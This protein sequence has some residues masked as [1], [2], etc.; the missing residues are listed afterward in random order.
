MGAQ[1]VDADAYRQFMSSFPT[2]VVVVTTVGPD[3]APCGLT[4]SSMTSVSL[5]PPVLSICLGAWSGTLAALRAHGWFAVNLLDADGRSTAEQFAK[6]GVDHF[7]Q[8]RWQA[9]D[10]GDT[11]RLSEHVIGFAACRVM[12]MQTI[13]DHTVVFGEVVASDHAGPGRPLL[14]GLRQFTAWPVSLPVATS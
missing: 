14:Y 12:A 4:C 7:Q 5:A 1:P 10:V 3:G 13:G 8:V 11:P 2:G 6:R 9:S